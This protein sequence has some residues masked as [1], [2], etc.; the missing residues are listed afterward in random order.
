V[1]VS[2]GTSST[3]DGSISGN[4]S[5]LNKISVTENAGGGTTFNVTAPVRNLTVDVSGEQTWTG[6]A[7]S[8]CTFRFSGSAPSNA[9]YTPQN[10]LELE[11]KSSSNKFVA[12]SGE[13]SIAFGKK[14]TKDTVK[15]GKADGSADVVKVD[16]L[17]KVK[18]LKIKNFGQ[19]DTLKVGKRS[20]DYDQLQD[21]SFKNISIKFD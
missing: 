3:R 15:L 16:S 2:S 13:D 10:K 7:V 6:T 18:D 20:F 1:S 9:L 11:V 5:T 17:N 8:E 19:D 4:Q 14:T 12:T 21:K